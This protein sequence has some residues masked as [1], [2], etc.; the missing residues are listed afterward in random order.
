MALVSLGHRDSESRRGGLS[1]FG[2]SIC[3]KR[4]ADITQMAYLSAAMDFSPARERRIDPRNES[5][6][7]MHPCLDHNALQ[8][9]PNGMNRDSLRGCYLTGTETRDQAPKRALFGA[10]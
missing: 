3:S 8:M 6:L 1:L 9:G 4:E 5:G 7:G 2:L 10:R